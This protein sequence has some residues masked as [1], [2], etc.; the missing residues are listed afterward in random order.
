MITERGESLR[1]PGEGQ[2][3]TYRFLTGNESALPRWDTDTSSFRLTC[4][5]LLKILQHRRQVQLEMFRMSKDVLL[6]ARTA[7]QRPPDA[8]DVQT[9]LTFFYQW[10][11]LVEPGAVKPVSD[12]S[13]ELFKTMQENMEVFE[14]FKDGIKIQG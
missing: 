4:F 3:R 9:L 13:D 1:I 14:K 6:A 7:E 10:Q 11:K 5:T 8:K 12:T 2:Y